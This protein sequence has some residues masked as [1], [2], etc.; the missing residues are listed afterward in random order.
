MLTSGCDHRG[1][2]L[3]NTAYVNV[4]YRFIGIRY[5]EV[6]RCVEPYVRFIKRLQNTKLINR[7]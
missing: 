6:F 7:T 2:L 5:D 4:E 1:G 3:E